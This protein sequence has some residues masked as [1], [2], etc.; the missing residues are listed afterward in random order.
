MANGFLTGIQLPT[1]I[2]RGAVGGPRFNTTVLELDSGFEKRNINWTQVRGE[3][4]IGY[5]L[6][7]K[8]R[9]DPA[10]IQVD[11]DQL[12]HFF[13]AVQGR[14]FSWRFKD[15]SDF[16]IG[17]ENG[18]D[19]SRQFLGFG[20]GSTLPF[21]VFKRYSF[22]SI[23]YDRTITKL[24]GSTTRVYIEGALQ[25]LTTD[26]TLD[27]DR[28]IVTFITAPAATGGSGPGGA[29]VIEIRTEFDVHVRFD[30]DDLKVNMAI[31]NAG[32]WP[33]IPIVE[34]RGT[35]LA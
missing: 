11:L 18:E 21:Q 16:E 28:G 33:N 10:D 9:D 2:E 15:W 26:Y 7:N 23:N 8:F 32:S 13:Y 12:I 24:V 35:G 4:D 30:T 5:G 27:E 19:I 6:M 3:W 29:E 20:D 31:F 14:A 22:G 1:D 17:M 25:T 34:I